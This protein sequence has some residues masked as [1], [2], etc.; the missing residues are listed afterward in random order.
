MHTCGTHGEPANQGTVCHCYSTNVS[1]WGLQEKAMQSAQPATGGAAEE[2]R[3]QGASTM[4]SKTLDQ[5]ISRTQ[6][7]TRLGP[8]ALDS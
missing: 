3:A 7:D 1:T 4:F 6:R 2:L 8:G 5:N